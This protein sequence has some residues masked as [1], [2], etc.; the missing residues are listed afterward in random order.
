MKNTLAI[1]FILLFIYPALSQK[2]EIVSTHT[3]DKYTYHIQLPEGFKP[4]NAYNLVIYLDEHLKSGTYIKPIAKAL[5]QD[6]IIAKSIFVG[7]RQYGKNSTKRRR[8]FIQGHL[9]DEENKS[10]Y[11]DDK[12][13]GQSEKFHDF[14]KH[15]LLPALEK[16]YLVSSK[17]IVGHSLGG[18]FVISCLLREDRLFDNY[19]AISPS[20]WAN[21]QNI[22]RVEEWF[23]EHNTSIK[24][25]LFLTCGSYENINLI[26]YHVDLMANRLEKRNY[27]GLVYKKVIF[28]GKNHISVLKPSLKEGLTY[29]LKP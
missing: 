16:D 24:A 9:I 17:T 29:L 18:L 23:N 7:I 22:F 3:G 25:R 27:S 21:Y 13:Y 14:L 19:L 15:E 11:S 6:K 1:A 10:Y 2:K 28:S 5:Q 12:N 26:R 20:L 4:D 8:D